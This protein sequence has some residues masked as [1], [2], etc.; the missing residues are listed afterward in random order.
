[1]TH[2]S[3]FSG[4]GG[5]DLAAE[6]AGFETVGQCEWADYPT[7]VLEKHWPDVPRWRDIRTL[8]KESFYERTGRT[9]VDVISGGFPCQPFSVAGKQKGKEDNR[10]LW[11]EMLRVIRELKP[12]YV[13]GENVPGIINIAA[14]EVCADLEREGYEVRIFN[15]EAA[16]VGAPH[17]R[18]RV[19]FVG[20]A[21]HN[22]QPAVTQLRSHETTG[23]GWRTEEQETAGESEGTNRPADVPSVCGRKCGS[24]CAEN[25]ANRVCDGHSDREPQILTAEAGEYAFG[26]A[27]GRGEDE[28]DTEGNRPKPPDRT[29][30]VQGERYGEGPVGGTDI[31]ARPTESGFPQ[32]RLGGNLDGFS[33]FLDG[34]RWPAGYGQQQYDWEPPRTAH[35]IKHRA[36]RI[37]CL[38]NAVVPQQ[39]YP[40]FK[41]IAEVEL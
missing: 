26:D 28:A 33:A 7:K 19:A 21:E 1:M 24:E 11:P 40:I 3:L 31:Q 9:T 38:G 30:A 4:I 2:L 17:R 8:T 14:D 6:W 12:H 29:T 34:L 18:D 41:A 39:F 36:D 10:Y 15:F 32:S 20:N 35:G 22:G 25:V 27:A 13:V 5:L 37:K 23:N 16:A